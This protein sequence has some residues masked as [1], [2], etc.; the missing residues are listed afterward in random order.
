M[1]GVAIFL[2]LVVVAVQAQSLRRLRQDLEREGRA[3]DKLRQKARKLAD[4]A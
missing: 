2:L 3:L 4:D 1:A